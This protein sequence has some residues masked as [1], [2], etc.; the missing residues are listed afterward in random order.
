[1]SY[2]SHSRPPLLYLVIS[3]EA[4]QSIFTDLE[5]SLILK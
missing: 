4:E 1:M 2:L 3:N 5:S